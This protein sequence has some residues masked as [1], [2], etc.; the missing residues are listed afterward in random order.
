MSI[1]SE[2]AMN[3]YSAYVPC[4]NNERSVEHTLHSLQRQTIAP[5]ELFLVDDGST[6]NS[7][8]I[9]DH[10]G[11]PVVANSFNSG[12]GHV[13]ALA[14]NDARH[15]LVVSCDATNTLPSD[16]VER[17]LPRFADANVAAVFGRIWQEES[18]TLAD[19][20]RGRH[21][22]QRDI[23]MKMNDNAL[24]S[25]YGCILRRS[26]ILH[27]GNFDPGLRQCEDAELGARLLAAGYSVIHDPDLHIIPVVSNTIP[28]VFERYW[29][30]HAACEGPLSARAYWRLIIYSLKVLVVRDLAKR[31]VPSAVLSMLVPHY[32][33]WKSWRLRHRSSSRT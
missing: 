10:L 25:T 18:T 14:L 15:E 3:Q 12:R 6:D 33:F 5:A 7:K 17:A 23:P 24:L 21:L 4:Y 26:A 1:R 22:F 16:F 28:Q 8:R 32:Q 27:V 2:P 20:W 30:W 19:R 9:A 11:I 29:R 31:D 13:R